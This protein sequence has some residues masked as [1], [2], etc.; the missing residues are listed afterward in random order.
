MKKTFLTLLLALAGIAS[1]QA[2]ILKMSYS[3]EASGDALF[4]RYDPRLNTAM[5]SYVE[6]IQSWMKLLSAES[7]DTEEIY[8]RLDPKFVML[9]PRLGA[10]VAIGTD[11]LRFGFGVSTGRYEFRNFSWHAEGVFRYEFD[12]PLM[13]WTAEMGVMIFHDMS[14]GPEAAIRSAKNTPKE[15]KEKMKQFMTEGM[16]EDPLSKGLKLGMFYGINSQLDLGV[17]GFIDFT[18]RPDFA[19]NDYASVSLRFKLKQPDH[20]GF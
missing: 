9:Q 12:D 5:S 20:A 3:L 4:F 8:T 6:S 10:N 18:K 14:F 7:V 19:R 16:F 15:I 17:S 2:Q 11:V 1:G 13:N